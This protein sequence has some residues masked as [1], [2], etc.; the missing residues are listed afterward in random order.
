[1]TNHDSPAQKPLLRFRVIYPILSQ[2]LRESTMSYRQIKLNTFK[3]E[4][5]VF[6]L[7]LS[8]CC[9]AHL[10]RW[11]LHSWSLSAPKLWN[12]PRLLSFLP[13][14]FSTSGNPV[15]YVFK[16]PSGFGHVSPLHNL[17]PSHEDTC[18]WLLQASLNWAVPIVP[19]Y[20]IPVTPYS[21]QSQ[22]P[23]NGLSFTW[24]AGMPWHPDLLPYYCL[25]HLFHSSPTDF[26]SVH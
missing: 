2:M 23:Y 3:T 22:S 4:F 16:I 8:V 17:F 26:C 11:K 14:T 12:H 20:T 21:T 9:F 1:M 10:S 25:L 19:S 5:L 18:L 24:S 6:P 15:S 7:K 13:P